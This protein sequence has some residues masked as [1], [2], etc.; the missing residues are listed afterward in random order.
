MHPRVTEEWAEIIGVGRDVVYEQDPERI[1]LTVDLDP[2]M[3]ASAQTRVAVLVPVG[4]RAT[5][6]DCFYVPAGLA[7]IDGTA[8]PVSDAAGVGLPGWLQVSFHHVD[9]NGVSTWHPTADPSR[10]D[11]MVS[12]ISSI[13]A[14]L[15]KRCN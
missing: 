12:Y 7:L 4:Y 3:Y 15:A 14:F 6:P 5:P 1:E 9:A 13:E 2:D 10:G 8:L 11:N